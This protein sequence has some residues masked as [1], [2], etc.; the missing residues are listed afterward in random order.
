MS[1]KEADDSPLNVG[2]NLKGNAASDKAIQK[3][4]ENPAL[5]SL[6]KQITTTSHLAALIQGILEIAG[7]KNI[8]KSEAVKALNAV[9]SEVKKTKS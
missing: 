9:G 6:M 3:F 7:E 2:K 1:F 8:D 5:I 4:S